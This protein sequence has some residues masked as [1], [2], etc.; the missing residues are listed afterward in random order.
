MSDTEVKSAIYVNHLQ[1]LVLHLNKEN[2]RLQEEIKR[3]ERR[4][5]DLLDRF[6]EV[7]KQRDRLLRS[8][9]FFLALTLISFI[10]A[11]V[12]EVMK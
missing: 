10:F 6:E 2:A 4:F 9:L 3:E 8:Y 1:G 11:V 7:S 5:N 12:Q